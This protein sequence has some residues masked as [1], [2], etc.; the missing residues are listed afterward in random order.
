MVSLSETDFLE[1]VTSVDNLKNMG[2]ATVDIKGL[3]SNIELLQIL[4][5]IQARSTTNK[6]WKGTIDKAIT[7]IKS[8]KEVEK[9]GPDLEKKAIRDLIKKINAVVETTSNTYYMAP[10]CTTF[11]DCLEE[12]ASNPDKNK[13]YARLV[14]VDAQVVSNDIY[15][16]LNPSIMDLIVLKADNF[17]TL[18]NFSFSSADHAVNLFDL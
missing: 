12:I 15:Q 7:Y 10:H 2:K 6:E 17:N 18:D 1:Y 3:I 8:D 11:K 5:G 16:F 13:E 9:G 14:G 4:E